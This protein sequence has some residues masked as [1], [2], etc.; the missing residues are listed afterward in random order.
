M[1]MTTSKWGLITAWIL[2]GSAV[3]IPATQQSAQEQAVQVQEDADTLHRRW[4]IGDQWIIQTDIRQAQYSADRGPIPSSQ[5]EYVVVG[6]ENVDDV[7]CFRV[8]VRHIR[9]PQPQLVATFWAN[10]ESLTLV[11]CE[12]HLPSQGRIRTVV[13]RYQFDGGSTGP[14]LGPLT[15][16]PIDLPQLSAD[17]VA[18]QVEKSFVRSTGS[19]KNGVIAFRSTVQ[20]TVKQLAADEAK[21]FLA[22]GLAKDLKDQPLHDVTLQGDYRRVRQLWRDGLP[23]PVY[24]DDGRVTAVLVEVHR[25]GEQPEE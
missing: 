20:Q 16:V 8:D 25:S 12:T 18:N 24:S 4:E 11:R 23:W 3:E 6:I 19:E 7:S 17:P 15:A 14:S 2:A 22:G 5:W 9:G 21:P 10:C 1:L 13:Q